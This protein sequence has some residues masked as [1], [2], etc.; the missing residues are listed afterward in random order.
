MKFVTAYC[1][2]RTAQCS[3][4]VLPLLR[5]MR[6]WPVQAFALLNNVR[7]I[8]DHSGQI[9]QCSKHGDGKV[10]RDGVVGT[11]QLCSAS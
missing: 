3:P 6:R 7:S 8:V 9:V 11:S 2:W 1:G 4:S 5:V 10:G